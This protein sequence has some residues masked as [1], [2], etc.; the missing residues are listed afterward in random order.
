MK[1]GI[2]VGIVGAILLI[3]VY[4]ACRG[5][6]LD[7]EGR[8]YADAA[9]PAIASRWEVRE[10][11]SRAYRPMT[12]TERAPMK[13]LFRKYRKLGKLKTYYGSQGQA[14]I[15]VRAGTGI[16]ISGSYTSRADF[17]TGPAVINL[18]IIK[19]GNQWRISYINVS[20]DVFFR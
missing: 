15:S 1:K 11:E 6:A 14:T 7:K 16:M 3:G 8:Q 20:S 13:A 4:V 19:V 17:E 9:I 2:V 10:F 12:V 5:V 18:T